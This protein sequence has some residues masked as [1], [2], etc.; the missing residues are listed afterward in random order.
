MVLRTGTSTR[1]EAGVPVSITKCDSVLFERSRFLF[2]VCRFACIG[3]SLDS[4]AGST[5]SICV[6]PDSIWVTSDS[7]WVCLDSKWDL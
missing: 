3:G 1:L 4:K 6:F 5:V 7:K 2:G